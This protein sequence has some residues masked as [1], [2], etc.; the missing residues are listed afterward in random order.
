M[1]ENHI[2]IAELSYCVPVKEWLAERYGA[3]E[4]GAWQIDPLRYLREQ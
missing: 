3:K 1:V 4:A 2:P